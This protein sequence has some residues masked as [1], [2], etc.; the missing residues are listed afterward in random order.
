MN[1]ETVLPTTG[2][3]VPL[4]SHSLATG[5]ATRICLNL[6]DALPFD[7]WAAVGEALANADQALQWWIGDWWAYGEHAYGQRS[8]LLDKLRESGHNFPAFKTCANA[9][10][11]ARRFESSRRR[12]LLSWEHHAAV[13]KLDENEQDW[14][15]DRAIA[16]GWSRNDLRQEV[17]RHKL[18]QL[19]RPGEHKYETQTFEDLDALVRAGE[20]FGTIYADPPW[21]YD[22][23]GTRAATKNHYK[24]HSDLTIE[25]ICKMPVPQLSAESAHCHLWT[26]NGFIREA[27]QVM[28]AWGFT[29]KSCFV[30]VKPD[31]GI[32]NYWRVGHEFMLFGIK[33]KA[34]FSDNSQQ[35]WIYE[36]AGEHSA[37]PAKV[38]RIIEMTSP[39]PFLELFSRREIEG[40]TVWGNEIE[41]RIE[42]APLLEVRR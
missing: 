16:N 40:W 42:S 30:W 20:K 34:P 25:D 37:K 5:K 38:R 26:T 8:R 17:R 3:I 31:F 14:F 10:S 9:G 15:L 29:Y 33:G 35:S 18:E 7:E 22:N 36:Q 24:A 12:E 13:A 27:F 21:P 2:Q 32:G 39:G 19:R 41:R 4:S 23:Q 1:I 11:L 6:P 28:E